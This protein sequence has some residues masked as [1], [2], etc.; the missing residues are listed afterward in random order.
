MIIQ[1]NEITNKNFML[2]AAQNYINH[3]ALD[4]E[5]FYEDLNRFK[6]LKKLFTKYKNSGELKERLILNHIILIFNVF[7]IDAAVKM[8]FFKTDEE[9]YPALKTFLLYL[10]YIKEEEFINISCDLYVVKQLKNI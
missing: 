7:K 8:C 4:I 5:E 9:S 2:Y 10:N 3:R 6:Y 1:K